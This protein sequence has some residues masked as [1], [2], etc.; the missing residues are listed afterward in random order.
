MPPVSILEGLSSLDL[1]GEDVP[2][3]G[4]KW[5]CAG[6][7]EPATGRLLEN[8]ALANALSTKLEFTQQEWATFDMVDL[9]IDDYVKSEIDCVSSYFKVVPGP[10][11]ADS[12]DDVPALGLKG[13]CAGI[14]EPATGRLLENEAL[15]NALSAKLEFTPQEWVTFGMADLHIDDYVKSEMDCV[16][17]YFKVVPAPQQV[18]TEHTTQNEKKTLRKMQRFMELPNWVLEDQLKFA[19]NWV[20]CVHFEVHA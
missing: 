20:S 11:P 16:S 15:A 6:I 5:Q 10:R 19:L 3:L 13:Q 9:H 4:L 8:E 7:V 18:A 1:S 2:V 17:S 14:V 12:G